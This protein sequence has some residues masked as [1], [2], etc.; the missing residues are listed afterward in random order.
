M[1]GAKNF[2]CGFLFRYF[3]LEVERFR[4]FPDK[5]EGEGS[6]PSQRTIDLGM[7]KFG[8][9]PDLGSGDHRFKSCYLDHIFIMFI[10]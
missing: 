3:P 8:I 4:R 5:E 1:H 2:L 9:A 7:A 6:M 10:S